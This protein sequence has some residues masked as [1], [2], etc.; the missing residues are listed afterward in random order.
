[1]IDDA[2]GDPVAYVVASGDNLSSIADRLGITFD[3]LTTNSGAYEMLQPGQ[4]LDL[5]P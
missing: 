4:K 5:R 3:E 2:A 1:M